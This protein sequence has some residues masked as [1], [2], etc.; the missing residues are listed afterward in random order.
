MNTL[1]IVLTLLISIFLLLTKGRRSPKRVPPGS[2]GIPIVGHSLHLLRAMRANTA[3]KWL[4][5]R[6]QKYG[7]ISKLSLF[8]KPTVFIHGK[9]ANKFVFTSDSSTLSNSQPQSVKK[10]LGDRCLLELS[11]QDHKRVRDALGLFLK[12]ESLKSYVGKMDEEVRMHIATHWE[13][14]QEVKVL[15]LMKTLTFNIICALLFGIERGARRE[16]L[17]DWFQEMIEGMWS[18]PI[19]LPFT[20]YNRSLQASASI[21]NMMKHLIGEK[22]RELAKKGVNPHKDLISCM[23]SIR[24]E[25]NREVI[26]ENEIMDNV[27]LVMTAGHD[28]SSV[29]ITFLVRILANDPSIYAAILKEQEQIA[30]SK[31]KGELL[32]WDD[33]A[34]MKY[35]WRVAQETLRLVSPI[36]GGFRKAVKDIEYDGYLI[37]K[38]WQIFWV[39]NMTHM[40]SSIF[41][42]SSKFDPARF[43]NQ[44]SIPPY[45]FIPFG[46]GPRICPGY[47]FARIETLITIHHLVTQFTWK[48]LADNF[49]KRD[50]MPVPTEGLPIQI[51]PKTNI[52]S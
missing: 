37:P 1:F 28:T 49:F 40:D 45:C 21:R 2:L 14:K 42:E 4:Q 7:P 32:T 38:G 9:D 46:G 48:L 27:M 5:Q 25:N 8:G 6:I 11:G 39:T 51:M 23:L 30:Q 41:P 20:R 35:S 3:E 34:K 47:E 24:D 31:Q 22:R 13:G 50:P 44:A 17:V 19:N 33:L 52:T 10:L 15:P 16:K 36:F 12:P 26:D 43:N 29:L 18:I